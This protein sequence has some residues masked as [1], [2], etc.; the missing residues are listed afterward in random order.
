MMGSQLFSGWCQMFLD[1]F[2]CSQDALNWLQIFWW[3][4]Q[5]C[6]RVLENDPV[7]SKILKRNVCVSDSEIK[8]EKEQPDHEVLKMCSDVQMKLRIECFKCS[9]RPHWRKSGKNKYRKS[10]SWIAF[11]TIVKPLNQ[12]YIFAAQNFLGPICCQ[13]DFWGQIHKKNSGAKFA[14]AQ[15]AGAQF[16]GTQYARS[17]LP[18]KCL[19]PD[20]PRILKIVHPFACLSV[21]KKISLSFFSSSF[22]VFG[23]SCQRNHPHHPLTY[24]TPGC[25]FYFR[26]AFCWV[27]QKSLGFA[28]GLGSAYSGSGYISVHFIYTSISWIQVVL[29]E[30]VIPLMSVIQLIPVIP[31]IPIIPVVPEIP[32][33]QVIPVIKVIQVIQVIPLNQVTPV[34]PVIPL[35]PVIPVISVLT[36]IPAIP[37]TPVIQVFPVIPVIQVNPVI[38]V[39]PVMQV[40]WCDVI[41]CDVMWCDVM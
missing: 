38:T 24:I 4:S 33:I 34:T 18:Q 12:C 22:A 11:S 15:F 28:S 17:N 36:V 37:V 26:L 3:H 30:S 35:I 40:M 27:W 25:D 32:E 2:R 16:V 31:L 7:G 10:S 9:I 1:V 20:M 19:G 8:V 21:L 41:W 29:S 39:I 5:M 14:R 6:S 23:Q 13:S